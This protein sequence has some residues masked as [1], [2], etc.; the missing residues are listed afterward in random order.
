MSGFDIK[1]KRA[2]LDKLFG[3]RA[4]LALL[5]LIL[6]A[7]LML[8]RARSL[9]DT[10]SKQ[11]AQAYS[12]FTRLAQQ[13]ADSQR[14]AVASVET[15]VKS[16]AHIQAA[17]SPSEPRCNTLAASLPVRLPWIRSLT[18]VGNDGR[19]KC[20]N[21]DTL[22]G[23]DV[24][25]R[26]YFKRARMA[27]DL[28]F[29]DFLNSK[30]DNEP[31]VIA[32]YPVAAVAPES[33]LLIVAGVNLDWMSKIMN[34]L[35]GRRGIL[36][37]LVDSTGTVLA[38]PA[39]M[40][41]LIGRALTGTPVLAGAVTRAI[42]SDQETGLFS[43]PSTD[44]VKRTLSFSRIP[45]TESRLLLIVDEAKVA[46]SINRDIR[47]AYLLL[48]LV[49]AFVLI[50]ALIAAEKLIIQPIHKLVA[51]ARRFGEGDLSA[52]AAN[53]RLPA[54]FAPLARAFDAMASQLSERERDLIASNDRLTVMASIDMLSGLA[55]R[56]GFQSRLDF[57]WMKAQQNGGELSLLMIDVDHFK[58][59]N[60]TYGHPEGD[61][62]LSRIGETLARIATAT[63]GF[64]ARYGGEEFSLLLPN[65]ATFRA[66]EIG[67]MV[68]AAVQNLAI[69]HVTSN[70]MAVT[71]SVGVAGVKPCEALTT[72]DLLE[73]ADASLYVA[74]RNGRN[75]VAEHSLGQSAENAAVA[76]AS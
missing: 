41:R 74:K 48:G 23:L 63:S 71:V 20:A 35:S 16:A 17:A 50:G 60:D 64:A 70:H 4:R 3:I 53:S 33:D 40:T 7:P 26:D 76:L 61:T 58:L 45:G 32:A 10:R 15:V 6:V 25:D 67:E 75:A 55:N 14:E 68:R 18:I 30:Y 39:D 38:A 11:I 5:A 19:V 52:R 1:R 8:E 43:F 69:P 49:C 73:A 62:C 72:G 65:T 13:S 29:S 54:E 28:V 59:F 12:E 42:N 66:L 44:G 31:I 21:I 36:A 22:V 24:S 27:R 9:E 2:G 56:R 47:N 37:I 34:D 51:I 46:A 57:E